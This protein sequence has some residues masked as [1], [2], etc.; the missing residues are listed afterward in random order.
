MSTTEAI[1]TEAT[2]GAALEGAADPADTP[3][4]A[5]ES[6]ETE[7]SAEQSPALEGGTPEPSVEARQLAEVVERNARS[8]QLHEN[9]L[10]LKKQT[11]SA[12]ELWE[13]HQEETQR[14]I[15]SLS[16]EL[17]LFD[18]PA[19]PAPANEPADVAPAEDDWRSFPVTDLPELSTGISAKLVEA[20]L[21]TIG[22]LADWTAAGNRLHDVPGIGAAKA[23]RIEASLEAFW[24][25][26]ALPNDGPDGEP[27]DEATPPQDVPADEPG[28][29]SVLGAG[30]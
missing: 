11:A 12:K 5:A 1:E 16:E 28:D 14:F 24:Q 4:A 22:A 23:E 2:N 17:P 27:E 6:V 26:R 29:D 8:I 3:G 19:A 18:K 20:G 10:R 15:A 25:A 30:F 7:P 13:L 21:A 9:F